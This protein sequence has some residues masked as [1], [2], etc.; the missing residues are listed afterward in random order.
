MQKQTDS[1]LK[2]AKSNKNLNPPSV[3]KVAPRKTKEKSG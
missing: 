3:V 1:K 2:P